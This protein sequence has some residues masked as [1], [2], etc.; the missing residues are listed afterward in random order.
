MAYCRLAN[1]RGLMIM[2]KYG[3]VIGL[4]KTHSLEI[5]TGHIQKNAFLGQS[6]RCVYPGTSNH[7]I[8]PN[9][10]VNYSYSG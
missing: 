6:Q 7:G 5:V 4:N 1:F 3:A 9:D 8:S 10:S 2:G